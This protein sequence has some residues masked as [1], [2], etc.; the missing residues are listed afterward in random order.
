MVRSSS[1]AFWFR[2]ACRPFEL[3]FAIFALILTGFICGRFGVF[4]RTATR[5]C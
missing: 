4:D 5:H 3:H 2:L 1:G